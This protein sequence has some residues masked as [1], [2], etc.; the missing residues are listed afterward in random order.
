MALSSTK[1]LQGSGGHHGVIEFDKNELNKI[2][3]DLNNLFP[4][5]DTKLRNA[6]RSGMRKS[7]T[8]VKAHLKS[9]IPKRQAGDKTIRGKKA[10]T[11]GQ[12]RRSIQTINGKTSRGRWPSVYV[13]PKVKGG[14]WA[15]IEKSGYYF[16]MWN[17]GHHNPFTGQYEPPKRWLEDT[18]NSKGDQAMRS[19]IPDIRRL[20]DTRWNKK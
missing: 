4:S 13:G 14:N 1:V 17:Y 11:P 20:I 6:V 2:I 7:M 12:L 9:L 3:K 5:S 15:N 8:P 10:G 19:L 18:A 16:Y